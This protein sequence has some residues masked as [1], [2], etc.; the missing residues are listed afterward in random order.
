MP[1]FQLRMGRVFPIFLSGGRIGVKSLY[2]TLILGC[3]NK[4]GIEALLQT[5]MSR[6]KI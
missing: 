3:F 2:L 6:I 1:I 4:N 5:A